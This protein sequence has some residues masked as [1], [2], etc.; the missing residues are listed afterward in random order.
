MLQS[1]SYSS[2]SGRSS[3]RP[4]RPTTR[5][6]APK[7]RAS[8]W[9]SSPTSARRPATFDTSAEAPGCSSSSQRM[10]PGL[11]RRRSNTDGA[12]V[13]VAAGGETL[14]LHAPLVY[15]QSPSGRARV[16]GRFRL[17]GRHVAF[18]IGAYDRTRPLV[19]DPVVTYATYLNAGAAGVGVDGAGNIYVTTL[20]GLLKLSADGSTLLWSAS[21]DDIRVRT[22]VVGVTGNRYMQGTCP[23]NRSGV[24]YTCPTLNGLTT[25][26]P[27]SQGDS[28]AYV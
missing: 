13:I 24:V 19:I 9:R 6:S 12:D 8:P 1:F 7:S 2:R 18:E 16:D 26:R 20:T 11:R 4:P 14:R 28:G 5:G 22:L 23:Y 21:F 27:Q 3:P 17:R 25:G 10:A 15:Q